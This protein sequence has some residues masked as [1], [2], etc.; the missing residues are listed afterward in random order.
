MARLRGPDKGFRRKI[1]LEPRKHLRFSVMAGT[2]G[3]VPRDASS[4]LDDVNK[5]IITQLQTRRPALLRRHRHGGRAVRGRGAPAGAAAARRRR[6]AGRRRHRSDAGRVR[7]PGDDRRQRRGRPPR[8]SRTSC[9]RCRR[10]TTSSSPPAPSTSSSRS[11]A[12]TT[13]TCSSLLNDSIRSVP[14]VQNTET[15]VY[16]RLAKQTYTWGTR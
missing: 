11:C 15:F 4:M 1:P 10:S 7:P 8:A 2:I 14:G 12:R 16:L 13:S 3:P 6:H 5:A 9:P